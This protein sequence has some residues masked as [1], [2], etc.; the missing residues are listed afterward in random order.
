MRLSLSA[1]VAGAALC[2]ASPAF[3]L[4][5][6]QCLPAAEVRSALA[7]QA[8]NPIVVGNQAGYGRPYA[9]VFTSNKD[10]SRGYALRGDKPFGEQATTI[11]IDSIFHDVKLND[12]TKPGVPA[13]AQLSYS[14]SDI[15]ETCRANRLG[16]QEVCRAY[17]PDIE[18]RESNGQRV[19]FMARGS[20]INPRDKSVRQDQW[21]VLSVDSAD[22]RGLLQAVTT[23]GAAYV[24]SAYTRASFTQHSSALLSAQ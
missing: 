2:C 12:F 15:S 6:G 11:C 17:L 22:Q 16:Y 21:I 5:T 19:M 14:G 24:L 7:N 10:G 18:T 23:N 13:W 4:E 20:A 9:L 3:A 8:Q 1:I